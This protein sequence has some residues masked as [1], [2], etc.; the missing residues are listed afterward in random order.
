MGFYF[1]EDGRYSTS[2]LDYPPTTI[3]THN[4]VH[5]TRAAITIQRWWRRILNIRLREF[6]EELTTTSSEDSQGSLEVHGSLRKRYKRKLDDIQ[7]DEETSDTELVDYESSE[8]SQVDDY[9]SNE[10]NEDETQLQTVN[11]NNFLL[12]FIISFFSF[13][14]YLFGF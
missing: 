8:F 13:F 4:G 5:D 12:D 2:T 6:Q 1:S 7:D 9:S 14:K 11:N 10:D 3:L